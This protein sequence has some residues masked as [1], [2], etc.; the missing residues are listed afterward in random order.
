M[1]LNSGKFTSY[2][3]GCLFC[4]VVIIA[5][6]A[7]W[8]DDTGLL[9][10]LMRKALFSVLRQRGNLAPGVPLSMSCNWRRPIVGEGASTIPR[11]GWFEQFW[12]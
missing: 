9:S 12:I 2:L 1:V 8:V 4:L 11:S 3:Y 5:F 7:C 6:I 10:I